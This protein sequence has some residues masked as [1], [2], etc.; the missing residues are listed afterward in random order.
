MSGTWTHFP[1]FRIVGKGQWA[2]KPD[3]R[4]EMKSAKQ[5]LEKLL[6]IEVIHFGGAHVLTAE[7]PRCFTY[8]NNECACGIISENWT[9][10]LFSVSCERCK[11][12]INFQWKYSDHYNG[13]EKKVSERYGRSLLREWRA[14]SWA[15][16]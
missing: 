1:T 12:T 4:F 16:G 3:V 15:R 14:A 6:G 9:K 10:D 5:M 2:P 13:H 8:E 11:K 7:G